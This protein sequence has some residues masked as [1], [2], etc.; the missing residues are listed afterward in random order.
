MNSPFY[1]LISLILTLGATSCQNTTSELTPGAGYSNRDSYNRGFS[2]G[3]SDRT[4]GR[5]HK[6]HIQDDPNLPSAYRIDYMWGYNEGYKNP[7]ASNYSK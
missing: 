6:P 7:K 5:A 1:A 2:D 3:S 4:R